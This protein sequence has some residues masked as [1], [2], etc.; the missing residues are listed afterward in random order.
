MKTYVKVIIGLLIIA[1]I[2]VAAWFMYSFIN[3]GQKNFYVSYGGMTITGSADEIK[4]EKD[5]YT[6]INCNTL[7]GKT[8]DYKVTV[9]FKTDSVNDFDFTHDGGNVNFKKNF[10]A[11]DCTELFRVEKSEKYFTLVVPGALTLTDIIRMKFPEGE[12]ENVPEHDMW[13]QDSFIITVVDKQENTRTEISF[14]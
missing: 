7:T 11:Y 12:L 4:F 6:V 2:I 3:N 1:I 10:S 14:R 13:A 8:V 5:K 9:T